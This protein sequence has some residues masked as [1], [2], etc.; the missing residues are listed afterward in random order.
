MTEDQARTKWCPMVRY[1]PDH[2]GY[3]AP[4]NKFGL[5]DDTH[6][7]CMASDCMMWRW[8]IDPEEAKEQPTWN[9]DD[10]KYHVVTPIGY[11]GLAGN[12]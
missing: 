5:I 2:E 8:E 1:V 3:Y 10:K 11:C 9:D 4:G 6:T 7:S 12:D